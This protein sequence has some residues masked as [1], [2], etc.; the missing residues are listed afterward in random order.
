MSMR[1]ITCDSF[2]PHDDTQKTTHKLTIPGTL[3]GL[4]EYTVA[5]RTNRYA[6][7][8]MKKKTQ[9]LIAHCIM[10]Q[11][12]GVRF[13]KPVRIAFT[14]HEPN[15]K[16]DKDNIAFAKKFIFDALVESG[17]IPNDG[18]KNIDSF[19]DSFEVDAQ[20][21]RAEVEIMEVEE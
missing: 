11:L 9:Q 14:W 13:E 20:N 17:V 16:R 3:P 12:R 18:W 21:P 10:Q 4:N 19:S 5:S 2:S 7:A 15:R 8:Q 6:A 1:S